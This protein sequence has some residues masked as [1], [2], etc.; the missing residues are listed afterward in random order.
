LVH[1]VGQFGGD[2]TLTGL[3][4]NE[5]LWLV[6]GGA[7]LGWLGAYGSVTRHVREIEPEKQL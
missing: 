4:F 7:T 3:S 2:F 1:L 5:F 6:F